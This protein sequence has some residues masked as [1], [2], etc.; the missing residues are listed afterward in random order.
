M[1]DS[2]TKRQEDEVKKRHTDTK[3]K[4]SKKRLVAKEKRIDIRY[5]NKK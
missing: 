5:T 2:T 4:A 1:V 3:I